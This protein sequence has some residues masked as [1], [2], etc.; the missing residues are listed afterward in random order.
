[1]AMFLELSLAVSCQG[2]LQEF[3]NISK[4]TEKRSELSELSVPL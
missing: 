2:K 1:M 3:V 4:S